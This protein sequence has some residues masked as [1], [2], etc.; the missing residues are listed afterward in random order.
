MASSRKPPKGESGAAAALDGVLAAAD[1][2]GRRVTVGLSGGVDSVVLLHLLRERAAA[3]GFSLS[4]LHVH[5]GLSPHA[6]RWSA[7][8]RALCRKLGVPLSVSKVKVRKS[9]KGPEAA[10]RAARYAAF[11]AEDCDVLMLAH[12]L[13]DQAETVLFNL[14]RGAG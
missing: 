6:G 7:H 2:R 11:R 9:G 14:L 8:C 13:D 12:Q 1:L 5:H 3:H 10:A 4:A